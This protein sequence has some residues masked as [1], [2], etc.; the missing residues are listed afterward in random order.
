LKAYADTSL[1]VSLYS[2]DANSA[3][4][5][6]YIQHSRDIFLF[7]AFGEL[8]L[9]N[10]LEL[11]V[12]RRELAAAEVK[13]ALAALSDD[14]AGGAFL[15]LPMGLPIYQKARQLARAHTRTLGTR[16]LDLLHVAAALALEAEAF[17]TFDE[18]QRLLARAAG[19]RTPVRIAR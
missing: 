15:V 8:E 16:T 2:P 4:A 12:F 17:Y 1:L 3:A 13:R 14:I 19:L 7:T 9:T 5:A 6:R 11:R 10:A 18:R